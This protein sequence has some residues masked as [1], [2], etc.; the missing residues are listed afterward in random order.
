MTRKVWPHLPESTDGEPAMGVATEFSMNLF[1][2]EIKVL[3]AQA[4]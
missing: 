1:F 3:I 2:L 4:L